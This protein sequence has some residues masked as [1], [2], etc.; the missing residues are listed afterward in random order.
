MELAL[1]FESHAGRPLP[2]TPQSRFAGTQLSLQEKGNVVRLAVTLMGKAAGRGSF[3]LAPIT[4]HGCSLVP[5]GVGPVVGV[6][7]RP[8]FTRPMAV[9][10]HMRRM[11]RY[12]SERW[13]QQQHS[14]VAKQRQKRRRAQGRTADVQNDNTQK[15]ERCP[16]KGGAKKAARAYAS[17]FYAG[18]VVPEGA[19]RGVQYRVE[20][21]SGGAATLAPGGGAVLFTPPQ[22]YTKAR[23]PKTR[24][25][26]L[27]LWLCDTHNHRQCSTC[28]AVGRGVRH[29]CAGHHTGHPPLPASPGTRGRVRAAGLRTP[30]GGG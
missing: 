11:E 3:L 14:R 15:R 21:S 13:A 23:R 19:R 8:L 16:G 12:N 26:L 17:D 10:H 25:R 22:R 5:L 18:L 30:G 20:E 24:L 1:D 28:A 9:W 6:K 4:N 29:C 27:R 2:P 7:G